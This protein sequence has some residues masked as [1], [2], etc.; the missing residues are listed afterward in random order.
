MHQQIKS[1][2][3]NLEKV[4][5]AGLYGIIIL[6][7]AVQKNKIRSTGSNVMYVAL[8]QRYQKSRSIDCQLDAAKLQN[9]KNGT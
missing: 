4:H 8:V 7:C 3:I 6:H 1:Y 2:D 5:F 9:Y